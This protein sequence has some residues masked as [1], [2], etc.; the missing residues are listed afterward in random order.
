MKIKIV[1]VVTG[2]VLPYKGISE[3]VVHKDSSL[4]KTR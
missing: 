1:I 2:M 4:L 3:P